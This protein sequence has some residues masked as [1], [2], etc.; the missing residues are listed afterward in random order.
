[1]KNIRL[2]ALSD[3]GRL[4]LQKVN[5][6]NS[7]LKK[8]MALRLAQGLQRRLYASAGKNY[9]ETFDESKGIYIVSFDYDVDLG[10]E[11]AKNKL[12]EMMI[13]YGAYPEDY[14]IE[15]F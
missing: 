12:S 7:S 2:T 9:S 8:R 1:M 5:D 3:N 14:V 15:V 13:K 11:M 10:L 6:N 4:A